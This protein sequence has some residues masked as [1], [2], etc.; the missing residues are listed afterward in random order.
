VERAEEERGPE[1]VMAD[2]CLRIGRGKMDSKSVKSFIRSYHGFRDKLK[3]LRNCGSS[4]HMCL[5]EKVLH[6]E[7]LR[8]RMGRSLRDEDRSAWQEWADTKRWKMYD[9]LQESDFP[10][11]IPHIK[12]TLGQ[13][14]FQ[15]WKYG[16]SFGRTERAAAKRLRKRLDALTVDKPAWSEVLSFKI[17]V[18]W[19]DEKDFYVDLE[20]LTEDGKK[21]D[22]SFSHNWKKWRAPDIKQNRESARAFFASEKAEE[23]VADARL[24]LKEKLT[25]EMRSKIST[26]IDDAMSK[27]FEREELL[28]LVDETIVAAV[29][30]R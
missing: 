24:K 22:E 21:R 30:T 25:D 9:S 23:I 14:C 12:A 10:E 2:L 4:G 17:N 20:V 19:L 16:Y 8:G 11:C 13:S 5:W 6:G 28:E 7:L 27:G 1:R 15:Y 29:M 3:K 26:V 18:Q